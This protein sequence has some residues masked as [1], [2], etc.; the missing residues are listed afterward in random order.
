M[1]NDAAVTPVQRR[2]GA[3]PLAGSPRLYSDRERERGED[4]SGASWSTIDVTY[5][6]ECVCLFVLHYIVR[7]GNSSDRMLHTWLIPLAAT[8]AANVYAVEWAHNGSCLRA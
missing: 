5:G 3:W 4:T 7:V 1:D 2:A 8:T 6:R